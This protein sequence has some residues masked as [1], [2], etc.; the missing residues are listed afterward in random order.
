MNNINL[1]NGKISVLITVYNNEKYV[2]KCIQSLKK[3]T[4]KNWEAV[5]VDDGSIDNTS[6]ILKKICRDKKFKIITFKKN[7]GRVAAYNYGASKCKGQYIA[8][9]DSDDIASKNRFEQQIKFFNQN[10]EAKIVVSW[11]YLVDRNS[12]IIREMIGP[13]ENDKIKEELMTFNFIPHST[14]MYNRRFAKKLKI[15]PL[16]FKYAIDNEL[17]LKFLKHTDIFVIPKFLGK[18]RYL[19]NSIT[20]S[21]NNKFIVVGDDLKS[22]Q[23]VKKNFKLSIKKKFFLLLKTVRLI[24]KL[25][26]FKL[27]F[28]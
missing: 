13:T 25:I 26:I 1:K 11:A 8:I 19:S 7:K 16:R 15:I 3:Q 24:F 4:Y 21:K 9:L 17:Y 20:H 2:E 12:K 27:D 18:I 28:A 6:K 22:L 5:I 14:L 10:K 23:F